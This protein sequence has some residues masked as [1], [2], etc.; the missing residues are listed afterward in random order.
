MKGITLLL[1]MALVTQPLPKV[2]SNLPPQIRIAAIFDENQD[3]KHELAFKYGV[4][5]VNKDPSILPGKRLI[6]QVIKVPSGNSFI[7]EMETCKLLPQGVAAIFGPQSQASAD[8]IRSIV[9]SVEIPFIDTR[10]NYQ[11]SARKMGQQQAEYSINLHPDVEALGQAY[12]DLIERY[13]WD[14]ITILYEN[15]D[16]M[17]RLKKIF[18][19]TAEEING[20]SF[21]IITKKLIHHEIKGYR[22][23]LREVYASKATNIILDC[24]RESIPEI[25]KQA[26]QVGLVS[27]EYFYLV[28]SLDAHTINME[29][30]KH[31]GTNFTAF[32]LVDANEPEV[33]NVISSIVKSEINRGRIIE[34]QD[35][36]LDT[37]T[38]LIYDGVM[39]FALALHE[40]SRIQN[41]DIV[42][43]DC[44]GK[45]SWDHGSSMINYMKLGEFTG[46]SDKV[47][48]DTEG[49]R[50][51]F[52]LDVLELQETGLETIGT[53]SAP[54]GLNMS[55][56]AEIAA[57]FNPSNIMA[58]K[59]FV[60]TLIQNPP[61]TMLKEETRKLVGN[62]RF[63]GFAIDLMSEI[64]KVLRFNVTFKLV[65]DGR[66]GSVDEHGNWDGMIQE[67]LIGA[68]NGGA[69]FA[70]ADL[71]VTSV[72]AQAVD[73]SMPWMN[74]GISIIFI[75]P[76]RAPPSFL[77][78][79]S[80]FTTEVWIYTGLSYVLVS[81]VLYILA[82]FCPQ[83]WNNPLPCIE[84]PEEL[85]N[86]FSMANSFWFTIGTFLQ[87]GCDVA[88][89]A[90]STRLLGG[91]WFFFAMIM[92][93]SYTANLAAFLTVETL[94][95]PIDSAEDLAGQTEIKYGVLEG[96][97]TESFFRNAEL[98]PFKTM[99]KFMDL[100]RSEVMVTSNGEGLQKVE[101]TD[102]KY[103]YLM[104]S[105]SIQYIIERN[106]K[107][108][109]IGGNLDNKGYGIPMKHGS[110]YKSLIDSAILELQEGGVLHNLK[111]KWWK[112]KRG[113][114]ACV[115]GGGGE[116][117]VAELGLP[118]CAGVFIVTVVGC[119]I[120][121]VQAFVEL[122]V[123]AK[124]SSDELGTSWFSEIREEL[125]FAFKCHGTTKKVR[126]ILLKNESSS[127]DGGD[128][129]GGNESHSNSNHSTEEEDPYPQSHHSKFNPIHVEHSPASSHSNHTKS[130]TDGSSYYGDNGM[131]SLSSGQRSPSNHYGRTG[132]NP[133]ESDH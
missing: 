82:Q 20:N 125:R 99:W 106:C 97:S 13:D 50:T 4:E 96:G 73:F 9:D 78:F 90:I 92:V 64:A 132:G 98:E 33:Q 17:A 15:N 23:I 8:H 116:G 35:G 101:D 102:G 36:N 10:W 54:L 48:F 67:V 95:K 60:V 52:S 24:E 126:K 114:G 129:Q 83:E 18:D 49:L 16:S 66:Y 118:N 86:Q 42:P 113:G 26:Q 93:A 34:F 107:L 84:E 19:R 103:A 128:E 112:Q 47:S 133:F 104:E 32:R 25:L 56:V 41:I 57:I 46:L 31:G 79:L 94:E 1:V 131:K 28:T 80:P 40:L 14:T 88:P 5:R 127:E 108:T 12:V 85:E 71:S 43:L 39:L 51:D 81:V 91:M 75:K 76:R 124:Y 61:Y 11:P 105:A 55:R 45:M 53:W 120:A 58:N 72:R 89:I 21:R 123:G 68:E 111:T 37:D 59:T 69:D 100:H 109:Q 65:D 122:L 62:D 7:A 6:P 77:S 63:E 27:E 117:S 87:Q 3:E 121:T 115:D 2:A 119:L 38:A 29:D 130:P 22:E 70:V 30:F 110:P 74:L 44:N